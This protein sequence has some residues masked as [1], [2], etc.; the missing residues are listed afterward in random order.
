MID[1]L[2]AQQ[3]LELYN[4]MREVRSKIERFR[5]EAAKQN[6]DVPNI[7]KQ[8]LDQLAIA[9][10]VL[11]LNNAEER[12]EKIKNRF[13]PDQD[14]EFFDSVA[15][16]IISHEKTNATNLVFHSSSRADTAISRTRRE[17]YRTF[18]DHLLLEIAHIGDAIAS[19]PSAY[20]RQLNR[21]GQNMT[22]A[23]AVAD[24]YLASSEFA[25]SFSC[26]MVDGTFQLT[27]EECAKAGHYFS[28]YFLG[29]GI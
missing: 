12:L 4:K 28:A 5:T 11:V 3:R 10:N 19:I 7:I 14:P 20:E 29:K 26:S 16:D 22:P 23:A 18:G 1:N 6:K 2:D 15:K 9:M 8:K 17:I 13:P 27:Y 24:K 21:A 25:L